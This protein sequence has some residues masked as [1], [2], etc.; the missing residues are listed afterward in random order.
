MD[1]RSIVFDK[2]VAG[3]SGGRR[4]ECRGRRVPPVSG[5]FAET[6]VRI[7]VRISLVGCDQ[8]RGPSRS[9]VDAKSPPCPG[10]P[11]LSRA[12]QTGARIVAPLEDKVLRFALPVSWS[13]A[14]ALRFRRLLAIV[15]GAMSSRTGE[16]SLP[17]GRATTSVRPATRRP[18]DRDSRAEAACLRDHGCRSLRRR[19]VVDARFVGEARCGADNRS[20]CRGLR[21]DAHALATAV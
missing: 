7:R 10:R 2:P 4:G 12:P 20:G 15:R 3:L 13:T 5:G 8:P 19:A 16:R 1:R 14:V 21:G 6:L 17:S 11:I 18:S 9:S